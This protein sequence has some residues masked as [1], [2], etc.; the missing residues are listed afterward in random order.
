MA[1]GEIGMQRMVTNWQIPD[2]IEFDYQ[3]YAF[4]SAT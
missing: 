3:M 1:N 4:I 2:H